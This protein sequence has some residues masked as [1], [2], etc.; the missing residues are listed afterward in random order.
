MT[1]P[2]VAAQV[3]LEVFDIRGEEKGEEVEGNGARSHGGCL[4]KRG[5]DQIGGIVKDFGPETE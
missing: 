5:A 2:V 4:G 3:H 1:A